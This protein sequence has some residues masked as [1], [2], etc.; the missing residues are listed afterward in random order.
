MVARNHKEK[1]V[2]FGKERERRRRRRRRRREGKGESEG[3]E[4]KQQPRTKYTLKEHTS[5][6]LRLSTRPHILKFPPPPNSPF[7]YDPSIG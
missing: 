7:S 1:D 6:D 3:G 5:N 2:G 4:K